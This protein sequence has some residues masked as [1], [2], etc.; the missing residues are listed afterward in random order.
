M[1]TT[2]KL[3]TTEAICIDPVGDNIKITFQSLLMS[4]DR[5][6]TLDQAMAIGFGIEQACTVLDIRREAAALKDTAPN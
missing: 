1:K 4:I 2:V 3:S 5:S 6:L